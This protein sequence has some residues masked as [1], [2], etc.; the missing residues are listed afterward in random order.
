MLWSRNSECH[1]GRNG[2]HPAQC[3]LL[4]RIDAPALLLLLESKEVGQSHN[5]GSGH[6][7]PSAESETRVSGRSQS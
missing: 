7:H 4:Q 3:L 1:G 5:D 6:T 2:E